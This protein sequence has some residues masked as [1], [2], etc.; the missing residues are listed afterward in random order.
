MLRK[1]LPCAVLLIAGLEC[2]S[3]LPGC[4]AFGL[5]NLST[6]ILGANFDNQIHEGLLFVNREVSR[7]AVGVSYPI[8]RLTLLGPRGTAASVSTR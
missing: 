1:T 5:E 2:V 3:P 4:T 8:P 6:H 7:N